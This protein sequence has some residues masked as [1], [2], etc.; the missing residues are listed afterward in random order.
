MGLNVLV[1]LINYS[2]DID[3]RAASGAAGKNVRKTAP[4]SVVEMTKCGRTRR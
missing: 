3:A 4:M 2:A 1:D